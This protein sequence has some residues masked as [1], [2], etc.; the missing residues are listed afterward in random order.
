MFLSKQRYKITL[1][2][3][4]VLV[5]LCVYTLAKRQMMTIKRLL[6]AGIL[7]L[8]TCLLP[9]CGSR[10]TT[11]NLPADFKGPKEL[12]R[13][14]GVRITPND[15]IFLY[16]AGAKWLGTPHRLGG[17]NRRGVDCS[18]FVNAI[19]QDV[20]G[21]RL[22]RSSE[23]IL[24]KNCR[25]VSRQKLKEGDFVFFQT[26]GKRK[27]APSHVGVYLKNGRFIHASTSKGVIVSSL[28]EP[29]YMRTW[30]TGGRIK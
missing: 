2:F 9:S 24:K 16:N 3:K 25:K 18:G 17:T 1:P 4:V 13:L 12:A 10:K 6:L 15:N 5:P 26:D 29:Y 21:I 19:Y 27:H 28:S 8:T 22:A 23:D 11:V 14:Y 7:L 30:M 20:Y